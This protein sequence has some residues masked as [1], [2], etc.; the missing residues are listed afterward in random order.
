MT[1]WWIGVGGGVGKSDFQFF[2]RE[3]KQNH[4]YDIS[5]LGGFS[6]KIGKNLNLEY[7]IG[8]GYKSNKYKEYFQ[9]NGTPDGDIKIFPYPWEEKHKQSFTLTR[10]QVSLVWKI[11]YNKTIK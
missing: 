11:G 2:E 7:A 8:F 9:L 6:H 1:G 10:L 5:I 4:Y 3:G